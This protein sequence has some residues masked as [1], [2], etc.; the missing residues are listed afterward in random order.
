[1]GYAQTGNAQVELIFNVTHYQDGTSWAEIAP[2]E[3]TLYLSMSGGA[4]PYTKQKLESLGFDYPPTVEQDPEKNEALLGLPAG[5]DDEAVQLTCREG[6][7]PDGSPRESWDLA[8]WGGS[9]AKPVT[10]EDVM[11]FRNIW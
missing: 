11:K 3:R 9:K 7:K 5:I 1:M 10:E 6:V 4:K 8:S 2:A